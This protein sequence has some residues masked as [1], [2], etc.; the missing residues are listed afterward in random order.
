MT[1]SKSSASALDRVGQYLNKN[2]AVICDRADLAPVSLLEGFTLWFGWTGLTWLA[3]AL[4]LAV[5]EV[6]ERGDISLVEGLFGGG[7]VGFAQWL[8]IRPHLVRSHR[9]II[10]TAL[11]WA[12]LALLHIGAVG[13]IAPNTLNLL[14][15]VLFGLFYGFYVGLVLGVGQWWAMRRDVVKAWRWILLSAGIWAVAIAFG[16][17]FGGGLRLITQLFVADVVGLALAW[18]IVAALTG[19]ALVGMVYQQA[20]NASTADSTVH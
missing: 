2:W 11:S 3:F 19:I 17:L 15:R 8:M 5:V 4:S 10:V 6:G 1:L 7:L 20:N 9:W 16:W 12:A 18:A 14:V 13:W